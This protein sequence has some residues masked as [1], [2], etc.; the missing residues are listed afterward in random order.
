MAIQKRKQQQQS[1]LFNWNLHNC[2]FLKCA[3]C[4]SS[5]SIRVCY[6]MRTHVCV[7]SLSLNLPASWGRGVR[8]T[9]MSTLTAT[10]AVTSLDTRR[11]A[12]AAARWVGR[13]KGV[14]EGRGRESRN[15]AE[16]PTATVTAAVAA[17]VSTAVREMH[18]KFSVAYLSASNYCLAEC[19]ARSLCACL[20]ACGC[21]CL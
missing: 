6:C 11:H 14:G 2:K 18:L 4:S 16:E 21:V 15:K 10:A 9:P 8:A 5:N 7:C 20:S 17:A 12:A 1:L 3:V 13:K 19:R